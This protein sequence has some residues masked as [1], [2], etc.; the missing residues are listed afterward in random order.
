MAKSP[1]FYVRKAH[2]Y[3]GIALGIQF[4]F[5]T[6]SGLYFSWSNIDEI[7]GDHQRRKPAMIGG[8]AGLVAPT[9]VLQKLNTPVDSLQS[10][11]LINL[12]GRAH[13]G[14]TFFSGGKLQRVLADASSGAVRPP[15]SR[16]EAIQIAAESFS[17]SARVY[18]VR[19]IDEASGHHEYREKPL[20]AWAVS[21]EH[22]SNTTV[23]V[24]AAFGKVESFRNDKWRVFDWLWMTHT[25]DYEGRDNIN[26]LLLRVFSV[27]GLITVVSGFVLFGFSSRVFRKRRRKTS[28]LPLQKR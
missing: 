19:R 25:M 18:S 15:V 12:L 13:Y 28:P 11:Q 8:S 10:L 3:L 16:E 5:W 9:L 27:F 1:H 14:I 6:I 22:P 23:Y 20:P 4:M 24:S 7:H 21:F 26:N 2:R 17:D